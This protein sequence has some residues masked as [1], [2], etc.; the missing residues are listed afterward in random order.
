MNQR[1]GWIGTGVMGAPMCGH[2]MDAGYTV[3]VHNRTPSKAPPLLE[4]GAS[5]YRTRTS[6]DGLN[7]GA[8]GCIHAFRAHV[9]AT[10]I[11]ITGAAITV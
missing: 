11:G 2:I 8:H 9:G 4:H 1:I 5:K 10:A 6:R 3:T 7:S